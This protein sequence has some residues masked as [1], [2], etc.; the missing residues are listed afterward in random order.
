MDIQKLK[1]IKEIALE[2]QGEWAT[3]TTL[4]SPEWTYPFKDIISLV[5]RIEEEV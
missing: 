1:E 2:A 5:E 4:Y 3:V